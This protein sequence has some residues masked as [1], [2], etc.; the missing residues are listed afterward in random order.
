M[1]ERKRKF[2]NGKDTKDVIQTKR[3]KKKDSEEAE[4]ELSDKGSEKEQE[5]VASKEQKKEE[6]NDPKRRGT[7]VAVAGVPGLKYV[8][9]F[10]SR[11]EQKGLLEEID[12]YPWSNELKRRV[13]HYGYK[14]DYKYKKTPS[15]SSTSKRSLMNSFCI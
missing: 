8:T 9:G 13:Q 15:L 2:D 6:V 11:E 14:Y 10:L 1:E 4:E 3:K 12:K 7:E 5:Q